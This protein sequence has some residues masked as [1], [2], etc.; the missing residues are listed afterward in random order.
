MKTDKKEVVCDRCG[1]HIETDVENKNYRGYGSFTYR[2]RLREK[3]N[4]GTY[5]ETYTPTGEWDDIDLCDECAETFNTLLGLYG[6]P[7]LHK[8]TFFDEYKKSIDIRR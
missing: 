6:F 4:Y 5:E 8:R 1:K 3:T 2:Y 7:K